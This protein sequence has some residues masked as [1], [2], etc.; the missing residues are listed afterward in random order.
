M[1]KKSNRKG[2]KMLAYFLALVLLITAVP[3]AISQAADYTVPQTFVDQAKDYK[4]QWDAKGNNGKTTLFIGD[5]FMS[6]QIWRNFYDTYQ[7]KDVL[8]VGIGSS[9]A[10]DWMVIADSFLA[11]TSPKNI[12]V[13]LGTND[14]TGTGTAGTSSQDAATVYSGLTALFEKLHGLDSL[15]NTKIYYFG[16]S[17][18]EADKW[19]PIVNEVNANMKSWCSDK[20]W[21]TYVDTSAV[22]KSDLYDGVHLKLESYSK[23]VNALAATDI[24]IEDAKKNMDIY[25]ITG[26]SN[27][28]GWTQYKESD[29]SAM[30]SRYVNGFENIYYSGTVATVGDMANTTSTYDMQ[31]VKAGLGTQTLDLPAMGPEVGMADALSSRYN[32]QTGEYAGFIK[33]AIGAAPLVKDPEKPTLETWTS[34]TYMEKL[35]TDVTNGTN[36]GVLYTNFLAE[37]QKRLAEYEAAGYNPIIK[38]MY[39]MQGEADRRREAE[40][41]EAFEDFASDVRKD[42]TTVAGQDLSRMPIMVGEISE[43][44]YAY[45]EGTLNANREFIAMQDMLPSLVSDCY[46]IDNSGFAI[47][48]EDPSNPPTSEDTSATYKGKIVGSDNAHWNY[49]D[50]ITIGKQVGNQILAFDTAETGDINADTRVDKTDLSNLRNMLVRNVAGSSQLITPDVYVSYDGGKVVNDADSSIAVGTYKLNAEKAATEFVKNETVSYTASRN[51][52]VNGAIIT[53]HANG[54][55]T[56]VKD[57]EFGK[58]DFTVSTWFNLPTGATI[59]SGSGSYIIGNDQPDGTKG[60]SAT[61]KDGAIRFR[62]QELPA[63]SLRRIE[64]NKLGLTLNT[65]EWYNLVISRDDNMVKVY[66][67]GD[68]LFSECVPEGY[69]FGIRDL[70]LGAYVGYNGTYQPSNMYFDDLQVY[71]TALSASE[72]KAIAGSKVL[73]PERNDVNPDKKFDVKDLVD[74]K[75]AAANFTGAEPVDVDAADVA[76]NFDG[77]TVKNSGSNSSMTAGAYV[78]GGYET[79]NVNG[80]DKQK[81]T[82]FESTTNVTYTN[83]RDGAANGAILT[84]YQKG[85]YTVLDKLNLE[86]E[87]FAVSTWFNI[88]TADDMGTGNGCYLLGTTKADDTTSGFRVNIRQDN[89]DGGKIKLF[90]KAG[91][92]GDEKYVLDNFTYGQWHHVAVS[93]IGNAMFFYYDGELASI[94]IIGEDFDFGD[95]KVAFGAYPGVTWKYDDRNVAYDDVRFYKG[96]VTVAHVRDIYGVENVPGGDDSGDDSGDVG[97]DTGDDTTEPTTAKVRV[98]FNGGKVANSG[99]D[100][101]ASV[102]TYVMD[103]TK[104]AT[105]FNPTSNVTYAPGRDESANGAMITN[106]RYGPYVVVKNHNFGTKD[107]TIS[108]WVNFEDYSSIGN[109]AGCYLFGTNHPDTGKGFSVVLKKNSSGNYEIRLSA[110]TQT[111]STTFH[112]IAAGSSN[113]WYNVTLARVGT[114]FKLYLDGAPIGTYTV[115]N[116]DFGTRDLA[117]G[118][119]YGSDY[120][121]EYLNKNTRYD[122][123]QVFGEGLSASE[124]QEKIMGKNSPKVRVTFNNGTFA[125]TGT[126]T[127]IQLSKQ[128]MTGTGTSTTFQ[129]TDTLNY[130]T[131]R[132]GKANGAIVTNHKTG[133]YAVVEDYSF[134]TGNFTISTWFNLENIETVGTNH[135]SYLFGTNHSDTGNGLSACISQ[136]ATT[137]EYRIRI[138]AAYQSSQLFALDNVA[139]GEWYNL[140]VA[141]VGTVLNIYFNGSLLGTYTVNDFDFGTKDLAFGAYYGRDF[142]VDD[143]IY[144]DDIEVYAEGFSDSEVQSMYTMTK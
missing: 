132:D 59:S 108:T 82:T 131:G 100:T 130:T 1:S 36:M 13:N 99:T 123:I 118:A 104:Y 80:V 22:A 46:L 66:F 122:D 67:D 24:E 29:L 34:P 73:I 62:V 113:T 41:I 19:N 12:V 63:R 53:N 40:Y 37:V 138:R 133:P 78:L 95:A 28:A 9:A 38:G 114:E 106:H 139:S 49:R 83:G 129:A 105:T 7:G 16:I 2:H 98:N 3:V 50:C 48:A 45:L 124:I 128:M 8:R 57:Y 115:N 52:D 75:I 64:T 103:A 42:L 134:G 35:G 72:I 102:G 68:L 15:K 10:R 86:K 27:G 5:S 77:G 111:G 120:Q 74:L 76:V 141:R 119:Y 143:N 69:D 79:V 4:K 21:I 44:F 96:E 140:T 101:N 127:S 90:L 20:T 70:G 87:D 142:Y 71:R 136:S 89:T 94:Q 17:V 65:D 43:T 32:S 91:A 60:F 56:V 6:P 54:P 39:W 81:A 93:R 85:A 51:G 58:E 92:N 88:P 125:N 55:Y 84:N 30:D 23:L 31:P 61:L 14:I 47:T 110:T 11:Y 117:F 109:N 121:Y 33:Y 112:A 126:D 135:E 107:F 144:F 97:G 25:L 18:R 26:Q 137:G 116:Y